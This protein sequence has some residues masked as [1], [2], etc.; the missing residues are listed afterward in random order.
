[1]TGLI[2]K[3]LFNLS[4]YV[5]IYP[6]FFAFYAVISLSMD[7][8]LSFIFF[9]MMMVFVMLSLTSF[10]CD[11]AAKWNIYACSL[12][13]SRGQIVLSKYILAC[14]LVV[15]STIF[16]TLVQFIVLFLQKEFYTMEMLQLIPTF[17]GV[18][19]MFISI[20]FPVIY[21]FGVEKSRY[22]MMII[23]LT[24]TLLIMLAV[25]LK[26]AIPYAMIEILLQYVFVI[27][28]A[29]IVGSYAISKKLVSSL[30]L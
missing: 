29:M 2:L 22:I 28:I 10:A 4:R 11:E 17:V 12:P 15:V 7:D 16:A 25:N 20:L 26:I 9:S 5:K 3:D 6:L 19:L 30:E 24:P 8:G 14:L 23:F 21:K 18:A 1:M 13:I 27:G